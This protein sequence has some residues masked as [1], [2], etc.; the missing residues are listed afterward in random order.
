MHPQIV[1]AEP[2]SCPNRGMALE[3]LVPAVED[4]AN[5]E[6]RDMARRFR[7]GVALSLPLLDLAM[8]DHFAEPTLDAPITPRKVV[9][10]QL[11]LATPA[12]LWGGWPFFWRGWASLDDRECCDEHQLHLRD[13]QRARLTQ[14]HPLIPPAGCWRRGPTPIPL[15]T[16]ESCV[17]A[18]ENCRSGVGNL[19]A[20]SLL[21]PFWPCRP[22]AEIGCL[23]RRLAADRQRNSAVLNSAYLKCLFY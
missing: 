8:A 2:G 22:T 21:S 18:L 4:H 7:V 10:I 17:F 19:I 5:P 23:F 14:H 20:I 13:R 1:R 16:A 6:L 15:S 12:V 9:W 3:P 11:I